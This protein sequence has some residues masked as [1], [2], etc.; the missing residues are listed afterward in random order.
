LPAGRRHTFVVEPLFFKTDQ[1]GFALFE[2]GPSEGVIYEAL[3]DQISGALKGALLVQQV[4]EK[5]R[6]RQRLLRYIVD[7]TPD[8]HRVQPLEDLFGNILGQVTGLLGAVE[9]APAPHASGSIPP[10]P[11]AE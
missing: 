8:M 6:E 3:R 11:E 9:S 2:M 4:V 5:D 7:V 10:P 1:L